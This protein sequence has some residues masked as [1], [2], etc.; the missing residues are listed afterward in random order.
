MRDETKVRA[1]ADAVSGLIRQLAETLRFSGWEEAQIVIDGTKKT[2]TLIERPGYRM[3]QHTITGN[4][5]YGCEVK[6]VG[7]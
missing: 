1:D 5:K 3:I 6:P 7:F 4:G 2:I